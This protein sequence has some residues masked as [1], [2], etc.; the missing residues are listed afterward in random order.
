MDW[1]MS[2][3][4][5]ENDMKIGLLSR[6]FNLK[7]AGIGRYSVELK[8]GL[9]R[10]GIDVLPIKS[11]I[12]G[13][14]SDFYYLYN[15]FG[16]PFRTP[17]GCDIYHALSPIEALYLPL[18]EKTI[19]TV[20]D[21]IPLLHIDRVMSTKPNK[22]EQLVRSLERRYF[23]LAC[24]MVSKCAVIICVSH[25]TKRDLITNFDVP[26]EKVHVIHQGINETLWRSAQPR[27]D[28]N[29]FRIGTVSSLDPR[30][31]IDSLVRA[32]LK[33]DIKDS[34]LL[35]GG[36]GVEKEKLANLAGGDKRIKFIGFVPDDQ[37][38]DFYTSLNLFCFPSFV[39]GY[40]L[41]PVEAIA[42]GTPVVTLH[43]AIIPEEIRR[44]T[45]VTSTEEFADTLL[46][47]NNNNTKPSS[48]AMRWARNHS[49]IRTVNS[50]IEVYRNLMSQSC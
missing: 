20:H 36:N 18:K 30:K 33:A 40:G 8:D 44:H 34:E 16:L 28:D 41:P 11:G 23:S 49:W 42:C 24:R 48:D 25:E 37:L 19:A 47:F 31:R 2:E 13:E 27:E 3:Q 39:E 45:Y 14:R 7:N 38:G 26:K 15:T 5:T 4:L 1:Q 50:T 32:F 10:N 22:G 35:I 12:Y 29:L 9:N 46:L 6:F 17:R 43:D 21:L